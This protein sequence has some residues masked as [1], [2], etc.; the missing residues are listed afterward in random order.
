MNKIIA[1]C[2]FVLLVTSVPAQNLLYNA[3]QIPDVLEKDA[4][5]VVRLQQTE[6]KVKSISE[7]THTEKVIVTVLNSESDA[8]ELRFFYNKYSKIKKLWAKIYDANGK[9][10]NAFKQKDFNDRSAISSGTIYSDSRFK[11]LTVN[12]GSY[13]YTIEYYTVTEY[14]GIMSYPDHYINSFGKSVQSFE[15]KVI[16]P[17]GSD[18][19]SKVENVE[20]S[21][22][23]NTVAGTKVYTWTGKNLPALA[24]E[25]YIPNNLK[26]P[27]LRIAA[28]NFAVDGYEGDMSTWKSFGSFMNQLNKE[29]Q[30]L[31]I[32]TQTKIKSLTADAA[33]NRE[34]I[35]RIYQYMQ[36]EVRYVSVQLGIGGW[37][38][39]DAQYVEKNKYGDCK[40]LSNYM[41]S[42]LEVID[43][44]SDWVVI[45]RGYRGRKE[46]DENFVNPGFANHMILYVP[47]ED[48]WLECT[49]KTYPPNYIGGDNHDRPVLLVNEKG[50]RLSRTPKYGLAENKSTS[51]ANINLDA[52]GGAVIKKQ[53]T[54]H[55]PSHDRYRYLKDL[56]KSDVEK[57]IIRNTSLPALTMDKFAI[58]VDPDAPVATVDFNI[59]VPRYASKAGKRVFVPINN[60]NPFT[61]VPEA[62]E[63]RI[64]PIKIENDY[65]EKDEY[66]F[67][68]P[69]GYKVESVPDEKTLLESEFG[70]FLL[71]LKV[72]DKTI[73]VTRSLDIFAVELPASDYNKL[74]DF[75]KKIAQ[76]DAA[77]MVLVKKAT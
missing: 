8:N 30:I 58:D 65:H 53:T 17:E 60:L 75:Y 24:Y 20:L 68:L 10:V 66:V 51:R 1:F 9:E 49:S 21:S 72:T 71:E 41:K 2:C 38:S 40:A 67:D 11:Y 7:A 15:V 62:E 70:K 77:K 76:L 47:S 42:M 31:T 22:S 57:Y 64:H 55:G 32:E 73:T 52:K 26:Y 19:R 59:T 16:L 33:T 56:P 45:Y 6:Y 63:K 18:I 61:D 50:G 48:M 5:E 36:N 69:E 14:E 37:Q 35:K 13:P 39:F 74:R 46:I 3:S 4:D 28:T 25:P 34:K 43:I 54:H 29:R 12:H 23:V 44:P 27:V